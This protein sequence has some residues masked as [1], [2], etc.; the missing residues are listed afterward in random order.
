MWS[1]FNKLINYGGRNSIYAYVFYMRGLREGINWLICM[2]FNMEIRAVFALI[3]S[4]IVL[5]YL[6]V[7]FLNLLP[8]LINEFFL[9]KNCLLFLKN[10]PQE[11]V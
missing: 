9:G 3:G 7:I 5:R 8:W 11:I 10:Q 2:R 1:R 6:N 4:D